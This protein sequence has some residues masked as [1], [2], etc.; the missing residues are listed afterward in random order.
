[1]GV[2]D[3]AWEFQSTHPVWGA[4]IPVFDWL[5]YAVISIH[6]PR[7]GCDGAFDKQ[8][9]EPDEFQ[10]TH[11]V[12]GATCSDYRPCHCLAIS[13]HAP[14]V[15][16]DYSSHERGTNDN[17]FQS[18]HPVWGATRPASALRSCK[19]ISIH[20]PRVGCDPDALFKIRYAVDFNPRTPCGVRRRGSNAKGKSGLFQST[21]PVWGATVTVVTAVV[22]W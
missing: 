14:R 4:T 10:S 1:M 20:A 5:R 11:P 7:V 3:A 9:K 8:S 19:L 16:C 18:T 6:A 21:H 17:I 15:G 12:W 22:A 13:I 2:S